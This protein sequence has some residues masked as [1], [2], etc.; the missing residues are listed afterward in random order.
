MQINN[1]LKINATESARDYYL[2]GHNSHGLSYN[3]LQTLA[4][5][6][7][8]NLPQH[9]QAFDAYYNSTNYL[10]E[11]FLDALDSKGD[12]FSA[13]SSRQ[14]TVLIDQILKTK[15]MIMYPLAKLFD[16][17]HL[18]TLQNINGAIKSWDAGAVTL[19][20]SLVDDK[21]G[22]LFYN[23]I[24]TNCALFGTCNNEAHDITQ[25]LTD[26]KDALLSGS[27][28]DL[29]VALGK[30]EKLIVYTL[31]QNTLRHAVLQHDNHDDENVASGYISSTSVVPLFY[32]SQSY[33][34]QMAVRNILREMRFRTL[35]TSTKT[36]ATIV[37]RSFKT[38]WENVKDWLD[39]EE[40][41]VY[42]GY[43]GVC[44]DSNDF[45]Q[46]PPKSPPPPNMTSVTS[47][48]SSFGYSLA[49]GRYITTSISVSN[50]AKFADDIRDMQLSD[51]NEM[52]EIYSNG[53]N[54][55]TP[56]GKFPF[57]NFSIN[58][59]VKMVY[60]PIFHI[61]K[62]G[63]KPLTS[64]N[65]MVF[66]GRYLGAYADAVVNDLIEIKL[67]EEA[68]HAALVLNLWMYVVSCLQDVVQYCKEKDND[69]A[70]H[71]LDTAA[72]AYIGDHQVKGT[73]QGYLLYA[74]TE[75]VG[76]YF[77]DGTTNE[78]LANLHIMNKM[79][80]I[81]NIL[82]K[83][84]CNSGEQ[85][86]HSDFDAFEKIRFD[87]DN[88][89]TFMTI[90]LLQSLIHE[91]YLDENKY[92]VE[93]YGISFV[94]QISTCSNTTFHELLDM[95]VKKEYV[96]SRFSTVLG[97]IRENYS[98][99]NITCEDIGDYVGDGTSSSIVVPRC[100]D[101]SGVKE[102][103]GYEPFSDVNEVRLFVVSIIITNVL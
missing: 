21:N 93:L 33:N 4:T 42:Q 50:I 13:A 7:R 19:L 91:M 69:M 17:H 6:D 82:Q 90:P 14:R 72:A 39:C 49:E 30:V 92:L 84:G 58:A 34:V 77:N 43:G 56:Q 41:G 54:V 85:N 11:V 75:K 101:G 8:S 103:A 74:F 67:K 35:D 68:I 70:L 36:N 31:V 16:S 24:K 73:S 63:F 61:Y 10:H 94:P 64:G 59:D 26:G 12:D 57:A 66:D 52:A 40:I 83:Q 23:L 60:N 5:K 99:L 95:Y 80:D 62:Y 89:V 32:N 22:I 81:K 28:E 55:N 3:T 97:L 65:T 78:T 79:N 46:T 20:G 38:A 48:S 18:C 1:F 96:K 25:L 98:C 15:I 71:H 76:A 88:I 29:Q 86:G 53:R 44:N 27:C 100:S 45:T 102:L 2:H 87:V 37:F 47:V 9:Y 51:L